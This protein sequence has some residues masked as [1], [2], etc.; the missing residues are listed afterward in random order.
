MG[1]QNKS[2]HKVSYLMIKYSD[3]LILYNI[4]HKENHMTNHDVKMTIHKL[5]VC[6]ISE[7]FIIRPTDYSKIL[8]MIL[9]QWNRATLYKSPLI[10]S[11]L[12][13]TMSFVS[14]HI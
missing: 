13:S 12:D 7:F 5:Y 14:F 6:I 8:A 3:L 2:T 10:L 1:I 4:S 11:N 9:L